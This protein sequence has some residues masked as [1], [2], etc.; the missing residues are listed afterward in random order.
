MSIRQPIVVVLGHVD[1]GKTTLLDKIRGTTVAAREPGAISQHIGASFVPAKVLKEVC[2]NLLATFNFK[3][4]IPGL[5]FIDTP[6]HAAFSNLRRRGGSVA[7]IAILVIDIAQ[8]V[9]PQTIES[10]EILRAR[11][12]PFVIA[13][14]K[15]DLVPGWK[16]QH[17]SEFV[18]SIKKQE[19]TVVRN[20]DEKIYTVVG[21]LSNLKLNSERFDRVKDFTK[22]LAIIPVSAKTGEGLPDLLTIVSGLAQQYLTGKLGVT[23]GNAKGTVLEVLEDVGLGIDV[24]AIIYDGTLHKDDYIVIG[25][26]TR[27]ILTRV[28]A[29]LLPKPLDEIRDPREKFRHVE[30]VSAA[31]GVKVVAPEMGEAMAGSPIYGFPDEELAKQHM[32]TVQEEVESVKILTDKFGVVVKTDTLGSLEAITTEL[33]NSN[34]PV[35]I[36]DIGDISKRDVVEAAVVGTQSRKLGVILGFNT[37]LLTEA[38]DESLRSNVKIFQD[39]IIYHLLENYT[40]WV[41]NEQDAKTKKALDSLVR[42]GKLRA[43]PG[44]VFRRNDPAVF[45]IE[46]LLGRVKSGYTLMKQDSTEVGRVLQ[47]QDKGDNIQVA[48]KG[49]QVAISMREPTIGRHIREGEFLYVSVPEPHAKHLVENYTDQLETDEI[50]ALKETIKVM[51]KTKPQFG[52]GINI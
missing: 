33:Q 1:H 46:V 34:I 28:R 37:K 45:G 32:S 36:G 27:A 52:F 15:L 19:T 29:L 41:K 21:T 18:A 13:A 20:L 40:D 3:I 49:L 38:Y 42:P 35:R 26:K 39:N 50:E 47:I 43:L 12:T 10:I 22:N 14:N 5:L 51:R 6:G 30:Q 31:A 8:G 4:E 24:N 2:G 17:E 7:D 11:N 44:F 48:L 25:G 16:V 23:S 9:Q